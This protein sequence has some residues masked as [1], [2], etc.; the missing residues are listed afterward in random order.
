MWKRYKLENA[1]TTSASIPSTKADMKTSAMLAM[2]TTVAD[3]RTGSIICMKGRQIVSVLTIVNSI[4]W[5]LLTFFACVPK[6][7]KK[8]GL[9]RRVIRRVH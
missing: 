9:L 1:L 3:N 2:K 4:D 7:T 5:L 6:P 8:P